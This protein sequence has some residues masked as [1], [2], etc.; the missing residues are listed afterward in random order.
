M[1]LIEYSIVLVAQIPYALSP[2]G[3]LMRR[4][5]PFHGQTTTYY[6]LSKLLTICTVS[7][8]TIFSKRSYSNCQCERR[9]PLTV[10]LAQAPRASALEILVRAVIYICAFAR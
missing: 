5:L 8:E 7:G 6:N 4:H 2:G 10:L 3:A 9:P 1:S